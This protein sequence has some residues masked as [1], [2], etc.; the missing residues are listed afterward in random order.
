MIPQQGPVVL[1]IFLL[2]FGAVIA[3]VAGISVW[4]GASRLPANRRTPAHV[5][6]VGSLAVALACGAFTALVGTT[7]EAS[8]SSAVSQVLEDRYGVTPLDRKSISPGTEFAALIDGKES[9]CTV[10]VPDIVVCGGIRIQ[11]R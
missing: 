5:L 10:A 2:A 8:Y 1:I 9:D 3:L 4:H 6:A 11:T 7:H